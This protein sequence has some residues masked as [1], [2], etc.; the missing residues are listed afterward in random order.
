[1]CELRVR[2]TGSVHAS[3]RDASESRS[4]PHDPHH[5]PALDALNQYRDTPF[6]KVRINAPNSIVRFVFAP[7]IGPLLAT[8]PNLELEIVATD[9]LVDIVEEGFDAGMTAVKIKPRLRLTVVGSP[10]YFARH[11]VPRTPADLKEHVCIRNI[12]PNGAAY[13]WEFSRAGK[14]IAFEPTGSL[15][16]DDHELMVEAAM[17]GVALAYVWADRARPHLASGELVEC[18][19]SWCAPE[20]WLYLYYPT[21]R[22]ISAGLRAVVE[23]LR[24]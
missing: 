1:V 16:L 22:H 11:P 17:S 21:R 6:G 13:P 12:Y 8:N 14:I 4:L 9:R 24:V 23:A 5:I 7:V 20:D 3:Q 18:L 19:A 2:G 15:S 10:A